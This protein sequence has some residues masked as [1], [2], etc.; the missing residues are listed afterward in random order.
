MLKARKLPSCW[1]LLTK[2]S[3]KSFESN[4][5]VCGLGILL[6]S[7]RCSPGPITRCFCNQIEGKTLHTD[8]YL[9]VYIYV[10]IPT[11]PNS[12]LANGN[13][14]SKVLIQS[15]SCARLANPIANCRLHKQRQQPQQSRNQKLTQL[16]TQAS[17]QPKEIDRRA[18]TE[19]ETPAG[20]VNFN[21]TSIALAN[22]TRTQA[23]KIKRTT[24]QST[25]LENIK[26]VSKFE[27]NFYFHPHQ[28]N[29]GKNIEKRCIKHNFVS[30]LF[31]LHILF[32]MWR[33]PFSI[34]GMQGFECGI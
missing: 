17:T 15:G 24:Q 20:R 12:V 9:Y 16:Q 21:F 30:I 26:N 27:S 34:W 6:A 10:G 25:K 2:L 29:R 5:F 14:C 8:D 7:S 28:K 19:T 23:K 4:W 3:Q 18:Q 33:Q 31:S 32:G 11:N 1:S 22:W 13:C